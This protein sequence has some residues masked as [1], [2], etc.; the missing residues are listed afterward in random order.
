MPWLRVA[1]CGAGLREHFSHSARYGHYIALASTVVPGRR[2]TLPRVARGSDADDVR[3]LPA[4]GLLCVGSGA[5]R[6]RVFELA[7]GR[8][9]GQNVL[10]AHTDA[11]VLVSPGV[12]I[13]AHVPS[14]GH[15]ALVNRARRSRTATC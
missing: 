12:R 7:E 15:V 1:S 3:H 8:Q 5:G 13:R 4:A 2:S 6:P 11:V 10:E 14:E 9:D